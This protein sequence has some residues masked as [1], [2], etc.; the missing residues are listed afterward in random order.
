MARPL[1]IT[2]E[3]AVYH[4]TMRGNDRRNIFLTDR[5]RQH[6]LNKLSESVHLY[7]IRLYLFCQM[8]NHVHL[9]LE[10]PKGNLSRFMHRLQTAYTVYFNRKHRRSGHLLQG[11]FGSTLVDEDEYILKLSRYVHLNPVFVKANEKKPDRERVQILRDYLWS[12]YRSYI[13]RGKRLDFVDYEPVLSLM[14]RPKKTQTT[15]YRR[16]VEAGVRDIDAA[17][18]ETKHSS[19]FC[20]GSDQSHDRAKQMY[21][22]LIQSHGRKEDISFRRGGSY[23]SIDEVLAAVLDILDVRR[24]AIAHRCRNSMTRPVVAYALC[25]YAGCTQRSAAEAIGLRSGAAVSL[26]LK[27]LN[28]QLESDGELRKIMAKVRRRLA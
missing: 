7:D 3:G 12:S 16:F 22:E 28:E 8:T 23:H 6:F 17:F 4:V 14:G 10:T 19:R 11:R 24:E 13:G 21:E 26:Q 20:I 5:D 1:R 25:H 27:R 15:C 9:V 2:Y 18:I